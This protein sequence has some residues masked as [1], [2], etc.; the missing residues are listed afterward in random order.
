M[1]F[2][3]NLWLLHV[4]S[5][6]VFAGPIAFF[7][8][9]RASWRWWELSGFVVPFLV[10]LLLMLYGKQPK[11]LSNV[12]EVLYISISVAVAVVARVALGPRLPRTPVAVVLLVALCSV[13]AATYFFTPLLPE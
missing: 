4:V 3:I 10:W 11:S 7:G 6:S 8:R 5:A 1:P 12:G 9:Q 13:A 2:I